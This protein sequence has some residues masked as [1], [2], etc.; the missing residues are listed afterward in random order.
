M[1]KYLLDSDDYKESSCDH[2]QEPVEVPSTAPLGHDWSLMIVLQ[3]SAL[4][5]FVIAL[6]QA[7]VCKI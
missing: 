4:S 2:H 6:Q 5:M 1:A 3:Y 7:A